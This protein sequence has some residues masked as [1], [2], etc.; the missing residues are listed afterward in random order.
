M[1]VSSQ[2][3]R[4]RPLATVA[5]RR[6]GLPCLFT[7]RRSVPGV[8]VLGLVALFLITGCGKA[9]DVGTVEG[10]ITLNGE[11]VDSGEI[12]FRDPSRQVRSASG[13]ITNGQYAVESL[14]ASMQVEIWAFREV[15]GK[16]VEHNPGVKVPLTE[17]YIPPEYNEKSEIQVEVMKGHNAFDFALQKA[18]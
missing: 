1:T 3:V 4:R 13:R 5:A 6:P 8:A 15:P 9:D 10:T 17:Q 18:P 12:V 7:P 14:P 11:P 16:F 2:Y